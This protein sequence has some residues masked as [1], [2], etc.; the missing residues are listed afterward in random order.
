MTLL[1]GNRYNPHPGTGDLGC[2]ATQACNKAGKRKCPRKSRSY[3]THKCPKFLPEIILV[4]FQ[5]P[6]F[7]FL[8]PPMLIFPLHPLPP[9]KQLLPSYYSP[10]FTATGI[11]PAFPLVCS[12]SA[13]VHLKARMWQNKYTSLFPSELLCSLRLGLRSPRA[14]GMSN[15]SGGP[16]RVPRAHALI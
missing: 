12:L 6:F 16:F 1:Y 4:V 5:S 15:P 3:S 8:L 13:A 9:P 11:H 10:T 7:P 14:L 2:K